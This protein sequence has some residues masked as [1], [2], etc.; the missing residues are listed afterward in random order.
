MARDI[1]A[2]T[3]TELSA[4]V[5]RPILLLKLEFDSVDGG[6]VNYWT[7]IGDFLYAGDTY[8]G[9][10]GMAKITTITEQS[11]LRASGAKFEL[12]GIPG[13]N[14]ALVLTTDYQERLAKLWF[15]VV[16][17]TQTI[18]GDTVLVFSGRM[19]VMDI[20]EDGQTTTIAITVENRLIDLERPSRRFYT[21][22]DQQRV[23][24]TDEGLALIAPLNDGTEILWGT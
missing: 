6:D 7:G 20:E 13:A 19:D 5:I 18:V 10:G 22:T 16:N 4:R 9:V 14:I 24:S 12:S 1:N 23:F 17:A 2:A 15:A 3:I 21:H 8:I 11:S